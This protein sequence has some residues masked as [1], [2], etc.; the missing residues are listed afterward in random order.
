[1]RNKGSG[2]ET[3][4]LKDASRNSLLFNRRHITLH[5]YLSISFVFN[6]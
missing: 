6:K 5:V 4:N 2:M 1:M 3:S